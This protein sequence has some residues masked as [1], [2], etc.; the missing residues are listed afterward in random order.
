MHRVEMTS[1]SRKSTMQRRFLMA[2][3][4]SYL[5]PA[6]FV[7]VPAV[8]Q[9]RDTVVARTVTVS[10]WQRDVDQLKQQLLAM[11]RHELEFQGR[12]ATLEARMQAAAADPQ[13][14]Q[15]AAQ[16]QLIFGQMHAA[17]QEQLKLRRRIETLCATVKK[18]EGWIGVATTG[19]QLVDKRGDGT[20]FVRFLEPPVVASVDPGSPADRVGVRAGDV[21]LELGGQRLLQGNIVFAELLRP[22]KEIIIKLRRGGEAVT[23]KPMVEPLPQVTSTPCSWV[24]A[25]TAYVL[26]PTGQATAI[27]VETNPNGTPRYEYAYVSA[28]RD[29]A[30]ATRATTTRAVPAVASGLFAGP[31]AQYYSGGA[32]SL[33]GLQLVALSPESSRA[34]GVAHGILVNQVL[35]GT[36]GGESGLLGGDV[37]VS[38]DSVDLRSILTLQRVINRASDRKVTLVIVREK[39]RET[40]Q[41]TW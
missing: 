33:A 4:Y 24:D 29:T 18:P 32:S 13:R 31:M 15:L 8:A 5:L 17:G 11:R 37:L 27:R 19:F 39:K 2:R 28:R 23:L 20:T 35:P 14:A 38:A 34:L 21:L 3:R 12:L 9:Q 16:S 7:S 6:A 26:A 36:P 25:G 1:L 41:L 22:G 40:I 30:N 10:S